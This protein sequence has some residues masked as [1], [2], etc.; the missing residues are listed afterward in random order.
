MPVYALR[1]CIFFGGG[2]IV[3][4]VVSWC[5]LLLLLLYGPQL[6]E[7]C[8]MCFPLGSSLLFLLVVRLILNHGVQGLRSVVGP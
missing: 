1:M 3:C 7:P 2:A 5:V 6:C 4:N 8:G